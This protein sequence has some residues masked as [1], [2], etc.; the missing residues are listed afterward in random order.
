LDLG[1]LPSGQPYA[2]LEYLAGE[3]VFERLARLERFAVAEA[4]QIAR[5]VASAFVLAHSAGIIHRDIKPENIFLTDGPDGV[6]AKVLDF[7][8][9]KL[10]GS[11]TDG[12][13][14]TQTGY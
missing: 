3:T 12:A 7:G 5:Q 6:T 9:A 13:P 1:W 2:V 10:S 14:Q 11:I 8:I 4:I